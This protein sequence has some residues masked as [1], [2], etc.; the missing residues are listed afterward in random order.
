MALSLCA[1]ALPWKI[2]ACLRDPN[3][4]IYTP[5]DFSVR[6]RVYSLGY[7]CMYTV[8]A[9]DFMG[10]HIRLSLSFF[11]LYDAEARR[12]QCV[13]RGKHFL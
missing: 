8:F 7:I 6:E 13:W 10:K 9:A 11:F 4:H 1:A 3:T 5:C 12:R 2:A